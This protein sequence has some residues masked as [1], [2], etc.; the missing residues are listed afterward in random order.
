M[1]MIM[2]NLILAIG[3]VMLVGCCAGCATVDENGDTATEAA[4][5][6]YLTQEVTRI[7]EKRAVIDDMLKSGQIDY[8]EYHL[9]ME[10]CDEEKRTILERM[11]EHLK[12]Y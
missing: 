7:Y 6:V 11:P 3:L 10:Q 8:Y 4:V 9:L 2:K 5:R 1:R 12:R